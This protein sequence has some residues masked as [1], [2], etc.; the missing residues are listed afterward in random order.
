[1]DEAEGGRWCLLGR[2]NEPPTGRPVNSVPGRASPRAGVTA[3]ARARGAGWAS[4]G[5]VWTGPGRA[6]AGP[7]LPCFGRANGLRATWTSIRTA[8]S[9]ID[10]LIDTNHGRPWRPERERGHRHTACTMQRSAAAAGGPAR[11]ASLRAHQLAA[12]QGPNFFKGCV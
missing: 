9:G 7:N 10:R 5:T 1:M 12:G 11:S 2:G 8:D 4:P 6:W 3:Q